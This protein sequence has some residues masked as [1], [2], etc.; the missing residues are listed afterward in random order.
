MK[1]KIKN[2]ILFL[3]ENNLELESLVFN[4]GKLSFQ[5][6]DKPKEIVITATSGITQEQ[7]NKVINTVVRDE[8]IFNPLDYGFIYD[9]NKNY[10]TKSIIAINQGTLK[11]FIM[12][13][14]SR[15]VNKDWYFEVT[16]NIQNTT[17][18]YL[19]PEITKEYI[20]TDFIEFGVIDKAQT[21]FDGEKQV[22]I[23]DEKITDYKFCPLNF[24]GFR[25]NE[26][27]YYFI[28]ERKDDSDKITDTFIMYPSNR[29][30]NSKTRWTFKRYDS[31]GIE[32]T[33]YGDLTFKS[34][35]EVEKFFFRNGVIKCD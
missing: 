29:E 1:Q 5:V 28:K 25:Y 11:K 35:E 12:S 32:I 30:S 3:Q 10:F 6:S 23:D 4:K 2:L 21:T 13:A 19:Y 15:E 26:R 8:W 27:G 22:N 34:Y 20:E 33:F 31:K 17:R 24:F 14:K 18:N 7:V 9:E 16:D